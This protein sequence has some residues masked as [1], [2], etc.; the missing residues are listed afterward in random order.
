MSLKGL[1]VRQMVTAEGRL[2]QSGHRRGR[3]SIPWVGTV[4]P[5]P[6]STW[7]ACKSTTRV[8][9]AS[10]GPAQVRIEGTIGTLAYQSAR[11]CGSLSDI[12]ES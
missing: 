2:G 11:R 10:S 4:A 1:G 9:S 6:R 8:P 3:T 7:K 12:A 5:I